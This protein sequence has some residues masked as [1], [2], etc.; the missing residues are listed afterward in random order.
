MTAVE[1]GLGGFF[2]FLTNYDTPLPLT[3]EDQ[4]LES[5]EIHL[6]WCLS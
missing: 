5:T 1:R 2:F 3:P 6:A 4:E